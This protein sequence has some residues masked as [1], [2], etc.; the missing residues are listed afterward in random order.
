MI[1]T[2]NSIY[3]RLD[4]GMQN[5]AS[6]ALAQLIVKIVYSNEGSVTKREIKEQ[7]AV[8]NAGQSFDEE[9][10]DDILAELAN[11]EL[12]YHKGRYSLSKSKRDKISQ[13]VAESDK[14]REEII[15]KYFSG[16]NSDK[17]VIEAWFAEMSIKFFE[18]FSDEWISDL[19]A[20]TDHIVSSADSIRDQ[21]TR[22]TQSMKQIDKDDKAVL[23]E[24]FFNFV[25]CHEDIVDSYLWEYGTSAFASKLI[26][27]KHGV[28]KLTIETF[29]DSFCIFDT[30]VLLFIA[31]EN[32]YQGSFKAIEKVFED[33]NV[34]AGILYITKREY[35]NKVRTQK[36]ETLS[37][38]EK[39]GYEITA[40]PDD[41]FTK[42]A[43]KYGCK[44]QTDFERFFDTTLTL[45]PTINS[46][47]AISLKD[48]DKLLAEAIDTAQ[49]DQSLLDKLNAISKKIT[50]RPKRD[51]AC[52]HD[53]G[54]IEGVRYLRGTDDPD[55][56]K[57]FILTD[58]SSIN[59]Y[60]KEY[61]LKHGLPLALRVDTLINMLAIN[62]GGDTFDAADYRPLFAN[63]IRLGLIPRKD[64]FR[65]AELYQLSQMNGRVTKLPTEQ[66]RTIASEMHRRFLE[67]RSEDEIRRDLNEMITKGEIAAKDEV[68]KATEKLDFERKQKEHYQAKSERDRNNLISTIRQ[69]VEKDYDKETKQRKVLF[70]VILTVVA[71]ALWALISYLYKAN[72]PNG[73]RLESII[74]GFLGSA[75]LEVVVGIFG[76]TKM[77]R[78]R[79]KQRERTI[80]DETKARIDE[81]DNKQC[82]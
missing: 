49:A 16:L 73:T 58:D 46:R 62:N 22:R 21:V 52:R 17:A 41:D 47:V 34:R 55:E 42:I 30:N 57:C 53:V 82:H 60:S 78:K 32:K 29:K 1:D 76:G 77:L 25:N 8:V 4:V 15:E 68:G 54:L 66:V 19:L 13:S 50:R 39:Y 2:L 70:W 75:L 5:L 12:S 45:P 27:N 64:T 36:G 28:D 61:G 6:K 18:T 74:L 65:Q 72:A 3:L 37:N 14:R 56:N 11:K 80:E 79:A 10:I 38:L 33:L 59:Q 43:I 7:L 20:K 71:V 81:I 23:P 35:E 67:G 40:L 31:L 63:I 48:S 24:R 69:Q 26:R 9:E 51:S 44:E